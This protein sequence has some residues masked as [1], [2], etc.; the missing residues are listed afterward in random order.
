MT[1]A[2]IPD[3][4]TEKTTEETLEGIVSQGWPIYSLFNIREKYNPKTTDQPWKSLKQHLRGRL[5][6]PSMRCDANGNPLDKF[7]IIG[8]IGEVYEETQDA[9]MWA[10]LVKQRV[11]YTDSPWL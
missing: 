7:G 1:S 11:L 10:E 2:Y 4:R 3:S 5:K 8:I 9:V 6:N